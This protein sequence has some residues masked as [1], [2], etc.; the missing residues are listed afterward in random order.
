MLPTGTHTDWPWPLSLV[1]RRWNAREMEEP[2]RA[3]AGT[4]RFPDDIP[5]AGT[6]VLLWTPYGPYFALTTRDCLHFR[7]GFARP[8]LV[9]R[10]Y[11]LFTLALKRLARCSEVR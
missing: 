8:D 1:P 6:W 11:S 2:P 7:L 9:D 10:Y 5:E 3:L 4:S